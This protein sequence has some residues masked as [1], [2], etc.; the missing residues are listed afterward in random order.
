LGGAEPDQLD[1]HA[2][3]FAL[4]CNAYNALVINGVITHGIRDSVSSFKVDDLGF[5]DVEEHILFGQTVSLNYIEHQLIRGRYREPR[6]HV[7]LVC[8][9]RSCPTIRP[10]AYVGSKIATQLEDQS[11]L[12]ANNRTYVDFDPSGKVLR[13]SPILNWYGSD[14]EP[15]GGYLSWLAARVKDPTLKQVVERA[16]RHD[17]QVAFFDYDW[18]MNSQAPSHRTAVAAPERKAEF[19]SQRI[20]LNGQPR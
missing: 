4:L 10:E 5:F 13:L 3:R 12:F 18:S 17:G 11:R 7:A 20:M 2:E 15:V 6:V 9:A 8:A 19:G 16:A 14:W 1:S